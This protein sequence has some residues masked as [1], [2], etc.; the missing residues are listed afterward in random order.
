M[1]TVNL[2]K[3][4]KHS[5]YRSQTSTQTTGIIKKC[6][7]SEILMVNVLLNLQ[8]NP[9]N[10]VNISQI[11]NEPSDC[12]ITLSFNGTP[13]SYETDTGAQCIVTHVKR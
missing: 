4:S 13:M 1:K 12:N 6:K 5:K 8:R 9:E 3:I 11:K 7:F 10:L 2:H